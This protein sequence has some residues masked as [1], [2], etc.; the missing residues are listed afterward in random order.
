MSGARSAHASPPLPPVCRVLVKEVNWLG[1]LVISLPALRAVRRAFPDARLAVLVKQELAGFFDGLR[2]VDR[3]IAY[4]VGR[5]LG[6]LADRW[7]VISA[8]RAES[9]D[10][11]VVLPRS[12]EAALWV[13]LGRVPRRVGFAAQGR[14]PLL[15]DRAAAAASVA[16]RHQAYDYLQM[17]RDTLGVE[18]RVEDTRLEVGE[19]RRA[20]MQEWLAGRRRR[21]G[22]PLIALAAGAAYGPAKQWPP[23]RYAAL[24]DH[25][26]ERAECI[27]VGSP[28]ER[29]PCEEIAA[30]SRA[31]AI[32][33][34]GSTDVGD[35]V[36]VLSLC[37]GFA[38]NDSG[39]MHVAAALGIP[40]VGIFGSTEP[41]RTGPLGLRTRI[42]YR[43][44]PCSPCLA[45]TCRYGHYECLKQLAVAEVATA[46]DELSALDDPVTGMV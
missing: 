16:G 40:T 38:G 45:R 20:M 32:V 30:A 23:Q 42:L 7:R 9:F 1:D 13:A 22:A 25:L 3:V 21:P 14:G 29:P 26:A 31:G 24:I 12:F 10:L 36:A 5:R 41:Q 4:R 39:A 17:L 35:L 2:W 19:E 44:L 18:G 34:A 6:G 28:D 8:I 27:L 15:T 33:S 11:A 43:K 37:A 46:L